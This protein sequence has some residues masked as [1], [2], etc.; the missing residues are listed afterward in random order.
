MDTDRVFLGDVVYMQD[1]F[2]D[3]EGTNADGSAYARPYVDIED[4]YF[5]PSIVGHIRDIVPAGGQRRV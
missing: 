2:P 3:E 4:R 1:F 5:L